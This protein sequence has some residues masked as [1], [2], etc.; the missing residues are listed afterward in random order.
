MQRDPINL[1]FGGLFLVL[2]GFGL[3]WMT[4]R[5][6]RNGWVYAGKGL[7]TR[8]QDPVVFWL[9][10]GTGMVFAAF[11]IGLPL[12]ALVAVLVGAI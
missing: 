3:A 7:Y 8:N 10:V 4:R 6:L 9:F 1:V 5:M 12:L 2:T 11:L